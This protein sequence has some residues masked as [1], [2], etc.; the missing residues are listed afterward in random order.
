MA[1][2]RAVQKGFGAELD[3]HLL[4]DGT[5]AVMHD[6]LLKRMTGKEGVIEDCT[7]EDLSSLYLSG[8]TETVP[9]FQDVLQ[10]FQGK[11]PLIIELKT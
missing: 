4:S 5:L 2:R 1:F 11:M 10:I 6:S 3:V 9:T 7:Y 8:T